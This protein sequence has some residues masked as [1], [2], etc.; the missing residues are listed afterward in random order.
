MDGAAV[1]SQLRFLAGKGLFQGPIGTLWTEEATQAMKGWALLDSSGNED[2]SMMDGSKAP[3]RGYRFEAGCLIPEKAEK[4]QERKAKKSQEPTAKLE[5]PAA[6]AP[7]APAVPA[8][9]KVRAK[10]GTKSKAKTTV[11]DQSFRVR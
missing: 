5:S 11:A 8:P 3:P 4:E 9:K 6:E 2:G 7:Q 1:Q 10:K